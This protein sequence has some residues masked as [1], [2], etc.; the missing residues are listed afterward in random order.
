MRISN[1]LFE[2]HMANS[3]RILLESCHDLDAKQREIVEGIHRE[4]RPLIEAS[5]TAD[6]IKNIFGA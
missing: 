3:N 1:I 4:F 5:L 6:Q 2:Q